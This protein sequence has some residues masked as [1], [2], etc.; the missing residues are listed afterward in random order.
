MTENLVGKPSADMRVALLIQKH[1]QDVIREGADHDLDLTMAEFAARADYTLHLD[2]H[3]FA[4]VLQDIYLR[5]GLS[6]ISFQRNDASSG[7]YPKETKKNPADYIY[8]NDR[9]NREGH[10]FNENEI[11]LVPAF[12]EM[13]AHGNFILVADDLT[14]RMADRFYLR[15]ISDEARPVLERYCG[16]LLYCFVKIVQVR[17]EDSPLS[18][19]HEYDVFLEPEIIAP[20]I[21]PSAEQLN[22]LPDGARV[23]VEGQVVSKNIKSETIDNVRKVDNVQLVVRDDNGKQIEVNTQATELTYAQG[24]LENIAYK[25]VEEGDKLRIVC[26]VEDKDGLKEI[27]ARENKAYLIEPTSQRLVEYETLRKNIAQEIKQLSDL[28]GA[29]QFKEA[30]IYFARLRTKE[31]TSAEAYQAISLISLMPEQEKPIFDGRGSRLQWAARIDNTYDVLIESMTKLEFVQFVREIGSGRREFVR[32]RC[33]PSDA[34]Y[35]LEINGVETA[36]MLSIL[37]QITRERL[38]RLETISDDKEAY[39]IHQYMLKQSLEHISFIDSPVS[40][41][42][43]LEVI[44]FFI[45]KG[46]YDKRTQA[47]DDSDCPNKYMSLFQKLTDL[48]VRF[49]QRFPNNLELIVDH[50]ELESWLNQI[51]P[52]SFCYSAYNDLSTINQMIINKS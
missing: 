1:L 8:W 42:L 34:F 13:D 24:V 41:N 27:S 51:R 11:V 16:V 23:I 50:G 35:I 17:N 40:I 9:F 18:D 39:F 30:R 36:T 20:P 22:Q 45:E 15:D 12:I 26:Y 52:H 32:G 46:Y 2:G 37:A 31:L 49:I 10:I 44:R 4:E 38:G 6:V 28:I 14:G 25:Q 48:L 7:V 19:I 5:T 47:G 43:I 3:N 21:N 33:D 29:E